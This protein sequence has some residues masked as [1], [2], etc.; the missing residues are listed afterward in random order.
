[1]KSKESAAKKLAINEF[2][3]YLLA[4]ASTLVSRQ[5]DEIAAAENM[6]RNECKVLLTLLNRG[7]VSLNELAEIMI[8]KQPTL[9]RIVDAM[10]EAGWLARKVVAEDRRA[11]NISLTNAGH[12]QAEPLLV[13]ARKMDGVIKQ[14]FGTRQSEHLKKL[15]SDLIVAESQ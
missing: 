11:V 3:P 4:H 10:V 13:H 6:S 15:L 9:S 8:I 1:M 12:L 14:N 5:I 2:L 7:G